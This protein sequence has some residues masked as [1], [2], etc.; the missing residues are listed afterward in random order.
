MALAN[1]KEAP[2]QLGRMVFAVKDWVGRLGEVWVEAQIVEIKRRNAPT[3]FLTLRDRRADISC[4]VTTTSLVLDSAGPIPE[5]AQVVARLKARVWER[6]SSLSFEC[7]ELHVAGEGQLL[8]RLEQL[9]RKLQAEGLF[10][11]TRKKPIPFLPKKIGLITGRASDAERDVLT[12][13]AGRWPAANVQVEHS[14][15]QGPTAAEAVMRALAKLDRDPSIDV[16]II[17]RGGGSMED[18]LPF[19]DEGLV[20]A[21]ANATTPVITA[22]GHEPD[23]P[24]VDF[25]ADL[26]ASTPTDAAKR[27]VPDVR[28]EAAIIEE[29]RTRLRS[30]IVARLEQEQRS[31]DDIRTRPVLVD[32][33]AAFDAH[34]DRL[35]LLRHQL[36][37]SITATLREEQSELSRL[38]MGIRAMS[39]KSTL[40][41]GYAV[42]VSEDGESISS[43]HDTFPEE[44][45]NAY[46]ADGEIVLDVVDTTERTSNG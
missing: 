44:R 9:K 39:P 7:L 18:L 12:N 19:S 21:V 25:V 26:R 28:Q 2:L 37:N 22:I 33:T 27:V 10:D 3:Q 8:A 35:A 5:G 11:Q 42:L 14:L 30:A 38:L 40:E 6:T 41:R 24:I 13:I 34:H 16:I 23:T 1:S 43:V 20:R 4:Q 29:A 15:V 45:I 31:L 17:A 32:P 46:L 36:H